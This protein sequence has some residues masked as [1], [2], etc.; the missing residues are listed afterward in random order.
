MSTQRQKNIEDKLENLGFNSIADSLR[1]D[2]PVESYFKTDL[3]RLR[4]ETTEEEFP[5]SVYNQVSRLIKEWFSIQK[6]S[7]PKKRSK[8]F[9]DVFALAVE[10][11]PTP[12]K[13]KKKK[14]QEPVNAL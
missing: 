8:D 10:E 14:R 9:E 3:S 13:S 6:K 5:T 2:S 11:G 7:N 1:F 12:Q 4:R